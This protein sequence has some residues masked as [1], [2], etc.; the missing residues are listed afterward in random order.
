MSALLLVMVSFHGDA[1]GG[2]GLEYE[3]VHRKGATTLRGLILDNN[4]KVVR[5]R[6]VQ[7]QPGRP[8]FYFTLSVPKG[9]VRLVEELKPDKKKRLAAWLD[10]LK[11]E[12]EALFALEQSI[13]KGTA[14]PAHLV[15]LR[16][17]EW[18]GTKGKALLYESAHFR[19]VA[20]GR[21]ELAQL[22]ALYLEQVYEAYARFLPPR[23]KKGKPTTILLPASMADYRAHVKARGLNLLNPA[24]YDPTR[25]EV[26]CGSDLSRLCDERD[27]TRRHH[28][29][30]RL[31]IRASRADLMKAYRNNPP[32]SLLAPLRDA[33]NR[34]SRSERRNADVIA[35]ARQRLFARLYHEAF[36]AYLGTFVYPGE[37]RKVPLWLNEGLAQVFES[38]IVEAGELRVGHAEK[39]RLQEAQE[40]LEKKSLLPLL[41]LLRAAPKEF[42]FAHASGKEKAGRAYLASWA[43]AHYLLFGRRVIGTDAFDEYVRALGREADPASAFQALVRQRLP[44]FEA[45][46]HAYVK[47]LQ[48]DG[49]LGR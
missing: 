12:R 11:R 37:D 3:A 40:A 43:L 30:L 5:I 21:P 39:A 47:K 6:C 26:V 49:R 10:G 15:E 28:A 18:P 23:V 46:F 41:S 29:R 17:T 4:D 35:R 32:R 7:M 9:E 34:I 33:E 45:D 13:G 14:T 36:H 27:K 38:A 8:T 31:D 20:A 44:Q 16:P 1:P 2:D 19:L 22:A 42:Q 48:E 25:N 24:Y